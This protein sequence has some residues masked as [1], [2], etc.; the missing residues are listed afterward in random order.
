MEF[1]SLIPYLLILGAGLH[2]FDALWIVTSFEGNCDLSANSWAIISSS[3]PFEDAMLR[4]YVSPAIAILL[5]LPPFTC[6]MPA[7]APQQRS[8]V[9]VKLSDWAEY[10]VWRGLTSVQEAPTIVPSNSELSNPAAILLHWPLTIYFILS[11]L[12]EKSRKCSK[13]KRLN[14][15]YSFFGCFLRTLI[16]QVISFAKPCSSALFLLSIF[17]RSS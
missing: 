5:S 3:A 6:T 9:T 16:R 14:C 7:D 13:L 11:C 17:M 12:L 15:M 1:P 2:Q 10:Y 8:L 4:A